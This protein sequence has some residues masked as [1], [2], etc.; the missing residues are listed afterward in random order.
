MNAVFTVP[1]VFLCPDPW[2]NPVGGVSRA[3]LIPPVK[4]PLVVIPPETN[5][6]FVKPSI[7]Q[8]RVHWH[9]FGHCRMWEVEL[10]FVPAWIRRLL[11]GMYK[12]YTVLFTTDLIS[13][14]SRLATSSLC[15]WHSPK[16]N[17]EFGILLCSMSKFGIRQKIKLTMNSP[18]IKARKVI[19]LATRTCY[20]SSKL[21]PSWDFC[22]E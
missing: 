2:W 8:R 11:L 4:K 3:K 1:V 19:V 21:C 9:S 14:Q 10:I 15:D 6:R 22:Y 12:V 13:R 18:T 16:R 17:T 7:S 20:Y 5:F